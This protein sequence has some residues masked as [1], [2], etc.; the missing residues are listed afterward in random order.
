MRI[1]AKKAIGSNPLAGF[2]VQMG[3]SAVLAMALGY[4]GK[5]LELRGLIT[6]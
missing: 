3:C 4:W 1:I 2:W 5:R 6:G